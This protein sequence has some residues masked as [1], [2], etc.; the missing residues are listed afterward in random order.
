MKK[1]FCHN[2]AN[3]QNNIINENRHLSGMEEFL[4]E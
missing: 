2:G 1:P 3:S 4:E